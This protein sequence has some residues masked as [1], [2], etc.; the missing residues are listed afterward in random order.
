ME[1]KNLETLIEESPWLHE[2]IKFED[3]SWVAYSTEEEDPE[4][5]AMSGRQDRY[6]RAMGAT[7]FEALT[8][9]SN[10]IKAR[11]GALS[12]PNAE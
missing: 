7:P 2:F 8:I 5:L 9:L 11:K 10:D 12:T 4:F 3:G 6:I 1:G